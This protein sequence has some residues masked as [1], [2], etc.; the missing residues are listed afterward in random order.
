MQWFGWVIE[1]IHFLAAVFLGLIL[2]LYVLYMIYTSCNHIPLL[3]LN[4]IFFVMFVLYYFY[5]SCVLTVLSNYLIG[6]HRC[7]PPFLY[8]ID[9]TIHDEQPVSRCKNNNRNLLK[10]YSILALVI[11]TLNLMY[12]ARCNTKHDFITVLGSSCPW[13]S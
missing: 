2:P 1:I 10:T 6:H 8:L 5:G 11:F 13:M 12:M 3:L 9:G 4:M 7:T